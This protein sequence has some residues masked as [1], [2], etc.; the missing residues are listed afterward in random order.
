M[1][2]S[3]VAIL[4]LYLHCT[5]MEKYD[6]KKKKSGSLA[7][8]R[9]YAAHFEI[10]Q[11]LLPDIFLV[12]CA[13]VNTYNEWEQSVHMSCNVIVDEENTATAESREME[14]PY[15]H[16][17]APTRRKKLCVSRAFFSFGT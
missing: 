3:F 17:T 14:F 8:L 7:E 6:A 12:L 5:K 16:N 11:L 2:S 1:Q 15:Y 13:E 4:L 10:S 9:L